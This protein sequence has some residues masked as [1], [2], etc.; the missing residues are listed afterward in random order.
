MSAPR[1]SAKGGLAVNR[2]RKPKYD[3]TLRAIALLLHN[4]KKARAMTKQNPKK[5]KA[6][7]RERS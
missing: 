1:L 7:K 5:R 6:L 4:G 3:P 2:Q